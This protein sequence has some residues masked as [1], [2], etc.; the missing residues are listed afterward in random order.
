M[1]ALVQKRLKTASLIEKWQLSSCC[2][3]VCSLM[4]QSKE[5]DYLA[6]FLD[7]NKEGNYGKS[8]RFTPPYNMYI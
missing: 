7:S 4:S 6:A 3:S 8:R 5:G 2:G 1:H